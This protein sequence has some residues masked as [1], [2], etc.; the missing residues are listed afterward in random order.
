MDSSNLEYNVLGICEHPI[1]VRNRYTDD[2][3]TVPCGKCRKCQSRKGGINALLCAY[4]SAEHRFTYF[5]TLTYSQCYVPLMYYDFSNPLELSIKDARS[6]EEI[7]R[8][9]FDYQSYFDEALEKALTPIPNTL[10]YLKYTDLQLFLK[11]FRKHASC[12]SELPIRYFAC[13]E[14]GP[15]S[16]R[17]HWHLL[18]YID[19][20][21]QAAQIEELLHKSWKFGF[22]DYSLAR[23][24]SAN[25]VAQYVNCFSYLP[26]IYSVKQFK[27][28]CFH[29]ISFGAGYF[30]RNKEEIYEKGLEFFD[31][32]C[33]KVGNRN[34]F[35][36]FVGRSQMLLYPKCQGFGTSNAVSRR[37]FYCFNSN[38]KY[39]FGLI[40]K[41]WREL[42]NLLAYGNSDSIQSLNDRQ[43][44]F[45]NFAIVNCS[46]PQ[47]LLDDYDF[48]QQYF[49]RLFYI[50]KHFEDFCCDGNPEL[51]TPRIEIIWNYYQSLQLRNLC[52]WYS[53]M[54][55]YGNKYGDCYDVF[56]PNVLLFNDEDGF[57]ANNPLYQRLLAKAYARYELSSKGKKLNDK[58]NVIK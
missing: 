10:G 27:P 1:T 4:E 7:T 8:V 6:H 37:Y 18:L 17:C 58:F 41:P 22:V 5:V 49:Y 12:I 57:G 23:N 14:Y 2:V 25:Y 43:Y 21:A 45:L 26:R 51:F 39:H 24:Q 55:E 46:N 36:S 3:I 33:I 44:D 19:S 54:E 34:A 9:P 50:S 30:R 38:F 15:H 32:T 20:P 11:R 29:S 42:A 31:A 28:K 53:A 13:G 48:C 35:V 52:N 56:Y 40:E 47:R 16:Y